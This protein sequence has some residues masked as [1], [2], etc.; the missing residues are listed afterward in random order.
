MNT[1]RIGEQI[2]FLRK[3]KGLTQEELARALG[4][5]NQAVSKW[6][7][8]QCCPDIQLLPDIAKIFEVSIDKLLGYAPVSDAGD[9]ALALRQRA[10]ALPKGEDFDFIFR[11]ASAL[12]AAILLKCFP[13]DVPSE[14]NAATKRAGDG[15]WGYSCCSSPELTTAMRRGALFFSNNKNP[16][17]SGGAVRRIVSL[18]RPFCN[19]DTLKA[20]AAL[21]RLTVGDEEAFAA[22]EEIVGE[23][24]LSPETVAD[25]LSE[26]LLPF[27]TERE[28][29]YRLDGAYLCVVPIL[30]LLDF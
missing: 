29:K 14:F 6:E 13:G 7:S 5:T 21:Y 1:V 24:G 28:G 26:K 11:M 10:E 20:A 15:E 27:L 17:L 12:H 22:P 4:V 23:S 18:L 2:G 3:Q 30:T 25:C 9:L 16:E 8:A 19:T